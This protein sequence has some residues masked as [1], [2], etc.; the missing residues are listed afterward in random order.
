MMLIAAFAE[1]SKDSAINANFSYFV[2]G[3]RTPRL[4]VVRIVTLIM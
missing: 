1:T 2:V 3:I 4:L